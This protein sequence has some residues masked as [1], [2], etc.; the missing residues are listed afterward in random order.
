MLEEEPTDQRGRG[1]NV[2]EAEK[3]TSSISSSKTKQDRAVFTTTRGR[4]YRL[5]TGK[6]PNGH[7]RW[8]GA[9]RFAVIGMN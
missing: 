7:R 8:G 5:I 1:Q 3:L 9:Y 6:D 2:L 4:R